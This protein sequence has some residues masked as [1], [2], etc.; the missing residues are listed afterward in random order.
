MI[1]PSKFLIRLSGS[2]DLSVELFGAKIKG[3][4][5]QEAFQLKLILETL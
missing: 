1:S 2:D 4:L 3:D 5:L